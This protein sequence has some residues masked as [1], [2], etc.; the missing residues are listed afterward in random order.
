MREEPEDIELSKV[1]KQLEKQ[2][3]QLGA[4]IKKYRESV[5]IVAEKF[6]LSDTQV[7]TIIEAEPR[8]STPKKR[9]EPSLV[10]ENILENFET[11]FKETVQLLSEV[12]E[13]LSKT[14]ERTR[15]I[16]TV[17]DDQL[18]SVSSSVEETLHKEK[19]KPGASTTPTKKLRRKLAS[20][21]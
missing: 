4:K 7:D 2:A 9:K 18:S 12:N 13:S 1:V 8:T 21:N 16:S 15:N 14:V 19:K 5:P 10:D 6:I 17:L 3:S 11:N 20:K